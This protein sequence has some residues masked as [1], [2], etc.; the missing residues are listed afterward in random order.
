VVVLLPQVLVQ[1]L[2]PEWGKA[3]TAAVTAATTAV[4]ITN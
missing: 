1:L 2:E 4:A 3:A